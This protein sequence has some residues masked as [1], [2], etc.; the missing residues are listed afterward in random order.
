MKR[1]GEKAPRY[2]FFL[3]PYSD[4]RFTS[5]PQCGAKM[6]QRK[7][8]IVIY[9]E[10]ASLFTALNKHCRFCPTCELLI[11]HAD[12]LAA[13]FADRFG[14]LRKPVTIGDYLVLG[15]LDRRDWAKG[16]V[17]PREIFALLH[18]FKRAVTF[19]PAPTWERGPE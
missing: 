7:L 3:N 6:R 17:A 15:T 1:L 16:P 8:P 11:V 10:Q 9:F 19:T 4:A 12:E 5:C 14:E 2:T 18:D 13:F